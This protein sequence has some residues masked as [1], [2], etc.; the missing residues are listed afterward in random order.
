MIHVLLGNILVS[1]AAL[2]AVIDCLTL[3]SK[4]IWKSSTQRGTGIRAVY[5]ANDNFLSSTRQSRQK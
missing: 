2:R 5:S 1:Y 4:V 3:E